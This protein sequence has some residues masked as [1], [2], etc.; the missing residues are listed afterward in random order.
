MELEHGLYFVAVPS[1]PPRIGADGA[2]TFDLVGLPAILQRRR[3]VTIERD[4]EPKI[5]TTKNRRGVETKK[6]TRTVVKEEHEVA[7]VVVMLH[8]LTPEQRRAA[9]VSGLASNLDGASVHT[10]VYESTEPADR[11]YVVGGMTASRASDE[12]TPALGLKKA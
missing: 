2:R 3:M 1:D 10:G 12:K 6:M 5:A 7:D 11:R 9:E 8:D 4:G